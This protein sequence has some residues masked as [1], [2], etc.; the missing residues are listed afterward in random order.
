MVAQVWIGGRSSS[1]ETAAR[2][3]SSY[4]DEGANR[5]AAAAKRGRPFAYPAYDRMVTGSGPDELNGGDLIAPVLLNAGP[6]IAAFYSLQ[7][8]LPTLESGLAAVPPH[9]TLQSAVRDGR[10]LPLIEGLIGLLDTPGAIPGVR[11]TTL[12]K[13]LHRKRPLFIPLFDRRVKACYHGLGD[14]Y[15]MHPMAGRTDATFFSTL[16]ECMVDDINRQPDLWTALVSQAP[17][18]TSLLRVLDVVAWNLGRN[19]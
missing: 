5:A 9:L 4:F 16:A 3:V 15:P 12:A 2:W 6:T 18:G 17:D 19:D 14:R 7:S 13:I 10:H 8:V 1:V 11:L